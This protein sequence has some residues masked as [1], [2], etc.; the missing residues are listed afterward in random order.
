MKKIFPYALT[1]MIGAF[2]VFPVNADDFVSC[3][4]NDITVDPNERIA[5]CTRA[6]ASADKT[7]HKQLSIANFHRA[8]HLLTRAI[9]IMQLKTM[10][11]P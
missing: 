1:M 6:I 10:P 5:A 8:T 3:L 9:M 4:A 2:L 11:Q 7:D